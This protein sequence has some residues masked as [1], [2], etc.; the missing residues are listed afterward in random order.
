M[1]LQVPPL[2]FELPVYEEMHWL[3][4]EVLEEIGLVFEV[5]VEIG[6]SRPN[7]AALTQRDNA[8]ARGLWIAENDDVR[9]G[10]A[11]AGAYKYAEPDVGPTWASSLYGN[12]NED[13][14]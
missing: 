10:T 11:D 7:E 13:T 9:V 8:F 6:R 2:L 12:V 5:R 14:P 1:S 3:I 4:F